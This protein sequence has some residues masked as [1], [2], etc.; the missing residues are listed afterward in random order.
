MH[1]LKETLALLRE[2]LELYVQMPKAERHRLDEDRRALEFRAGALALE[3]G[4]EAAPIMWAQI[5]WVREMK[6]NA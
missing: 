4:D 3:L 5:D 2:L 6:A 1:E